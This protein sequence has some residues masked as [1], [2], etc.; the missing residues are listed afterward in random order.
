VGEKEKRGKGKMYDAEKKWKKR[1]KKRRNFSG[2]Y[3]ILTSA[4]GILARILAASARNS[5]AF[6][7]DSTRGD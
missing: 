7:G 3:D 6:L 4:L 2:S 1:Q 5:A